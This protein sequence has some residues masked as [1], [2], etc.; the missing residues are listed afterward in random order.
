MHICL[1]VVVAVYCL[2]KYE[3][4]AMNCNPVL[5]KLIESLRDK[6]VENVWKLTRW[7]QLRYMYMYVRLY[8]V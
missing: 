2:H 5:K 4:C 1:L 8:L 3:L 6:A 7:L